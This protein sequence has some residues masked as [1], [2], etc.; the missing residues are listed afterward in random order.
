MV[1]GKAVKIGTF[2]IQKN[3]QIK[4]NIVTSF[5]FKTANGVVAKR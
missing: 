3:P 1:Y 4:Q 2:S 5:C